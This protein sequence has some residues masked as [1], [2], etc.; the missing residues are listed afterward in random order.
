MSFECSA[1]GCQSDVGELLGAEEPVEDTKQIV[2]E[3]VPPKTI[4]FRVCRRHVLKEKEAE[5][6][7]IEDF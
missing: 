7:T 2:L 1:F 3:I 6:N 5:K 4:L